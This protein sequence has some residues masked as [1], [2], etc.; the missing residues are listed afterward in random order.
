MLAAA[1]RD[2]VDNG[3]PGKTGGGVPRSVPISSVGAGLAVGAAVW[4]LGMI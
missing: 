4:A 2:W 3:S 1:Y